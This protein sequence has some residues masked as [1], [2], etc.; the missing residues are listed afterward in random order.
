[1]K[2]IKQKG[3]QGIEQ[4]RQAHGNSTDPIYQKIEKGFEAKD[5]AVNKAYQDATS[6]TSPDS[7]INVS[8][9]RNRSERLLKR[10]GY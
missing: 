1:I 4:T 2:T 5:Q 10:A 3:V 8:G 6:K 7:L 9:T